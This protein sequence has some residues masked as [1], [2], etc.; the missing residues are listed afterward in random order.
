MLCNRVLGVSL[1]RR[2]AAPHLGPL[3]VSSTKCR[4]HGSVRSVLVVTI[5]TESYLVKTELELACKRV[6]R[7]LVGS[8]LDG[9]DDSVAD[10][11]AMIAS[12]LEKITEK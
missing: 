6:Q 9:S 7:P 10:V 5:L 2:G 12:E 8:S 4:P 3:S 11:C 1:E